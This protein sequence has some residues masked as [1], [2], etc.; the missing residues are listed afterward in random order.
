M[1]KS[2]VNAINKQIYEELN[3]AYI[4]LAMS[5]Y[6]ESVGLKG[7][8]NWF[9]VQSKEEEDH[10]MGFYNYLNSQGETVAYSALP[11]PKGSFKDIMEATKETL[12]HEE[13]ITK[14]IHS[15]VD[16]SHKEKDHAFASMLQWYVDEQVEE[17]DS[18]RDIID[19]LTM[20]GKNGP[21]LYMLDKELSARTYKPASILATEE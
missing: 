5:A 14:C 6:A 10:A 12:K 20:V 8:A 7:F 2:I 3:S 15:L 16:L 1:K 4:Y 11:K 9:R 18:V 17:E 19:K 21:S 13:H